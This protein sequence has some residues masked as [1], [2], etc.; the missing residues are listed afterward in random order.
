MADIF[1]SYSSMDEKL[2]EIIKKQHLGRFPTWSMRD[3]DA[4]DNYEEIIISKL[5]DCDTAILILSPD[6]FKAPYIMDEELPRLLEKNRKNPDFKLLPILL[7][8]CSEKE[9]QKL[10]TINIHPSSSRAL[11]EMDNEDFNHSMRRFIKENLES[12]SAYNQV[13]KNP[14]WE[15]LKEQFV[16]GQKISNPMRGSRKLELV[17]GPKNQLEL[18]IPT[19]GEE[20]GMELNIKSISTRVVNTDKGEFYV[21][22]ILN[23]QLL[24]F[25]FTFCCLLDDEFTTSNKGLVKDI[26]TVAKRWK[27]LVKEERSLKDLEKGLLGELWFLENL[28][29]HLGPSIIRDWR[30][31]EG[32]R[33]D[34]RM[35]N[36]EFEIK[37]TSSD[38]RAHYISSIAQLEA[39]KGCNLQLVSIQIAPTKSGKNTLSVNKLITK[40][41]KKLN[42]EDYNSMFNLK[43]KEYINDDLSAVLKMK[44]NYVFSSE[45]MS[46]NVDENFPRISKNEFNNLKHS[47]RVSDIK[48]RLNVEG[49]GESCDGQNFKK[50]IKGIT[51]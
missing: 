51:F 35:Q 4:G 47:E 44:T 5:N 48:Y 33:H 20:S 22:K 29:T 32:D 17:A 43:L 50:I 13:V 16:S 7:R 12:L 23:K 2:T 21:L 39:S 36:E 45:P 3:G 40:I 28:I 38:E 19:N 1:I 18:Y 49:L 14:T 46:M 10:G 11:S 27:D 6:F 8:K 37:T 34:F 41:K 30:G 15:E 25:F 24:E 31:S 42:S 9:L 26:L